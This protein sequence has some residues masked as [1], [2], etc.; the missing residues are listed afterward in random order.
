MYT[1]LHYKHG[2]N[3]K[4]SHYNIIAALQVH[5]ANIEIGQLISIMCIY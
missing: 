4:H 3:F 5:A 2:K 1:S